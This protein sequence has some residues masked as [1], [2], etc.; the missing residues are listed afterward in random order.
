MRRRYQNTC[1]ITM[2]SD[3]LWETGGRMRRVPIPQYHPS[4]RELDDLE[5]LVTGAL[6]P[7][8]GFNEPGSPV[9]LELPRDVV[10]AAVTGGVVELVDP[11][12][13]P[14]AHV[15]LDGRVTPLTH[16][17]TAPS[18]GSGSHRPRR[19]RSTP[20]APGSR[21]PTRSPTRSWRRW[22]RSGRWCCWR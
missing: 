21:W 19:R 14:L 7:V 22:P 18:D 13:L 16:A 12:G 6:S 4:P 11:E 2:P 5:L 8:R 17:S 20:G 9:T 1:S 15:D 10:E 3:D